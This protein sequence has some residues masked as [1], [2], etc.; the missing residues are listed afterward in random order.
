MPGLLGLDAFNQL[1]R[2]EDQTYQFGIQFKRVLKDDQ[3]PGATGL[4]QLSDL[5]RDHPAAFCTTLLP[6]GP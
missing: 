6:F 1:E 4:P 3:T 2:L 5:S